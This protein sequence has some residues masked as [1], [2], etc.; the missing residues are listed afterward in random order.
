MT[1]VL[2]PRRVSKVKVGLAIMLVLGMMAGMWYVYQLW[3]DGQTTT[4]ANQNSAS[5]TSKPTQV[6]GLST[7]KI[8]HQPPK[9]ASRLPSGVESN[10]KPSEDPGLI[11]S[12]MGRLSGLETS[13]AEMGEK[14][15]HTYKP[16]GPGAK[17]S[18]AAKPAHAAKTPDPH[19]ALRQKALAES[20]KAPLVV[21]ST[22]AK[23]TDA[24]EELRTLQPGWKIPFFVE[25]AVHSDIASEF[26]GRVSETVYASS[27]HRVPL[28]PLGATVLGTARAGQLIPGNERLPMASVSVSIP[29][30]KP[31]EIHSMPIIDE[32][33]K[34]GMVDDIDHHYVRQ[35][36]GVLVGGFLRGAT[37]E[38]QSQSNKLGPVGSVTEGVASGAQ[39]AAG[40]QL[41]QLYSV[42][43]TIQ[44]YRGSRGYILITK[45]LKI[46]GATEGVK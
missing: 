36:F 15:S 44:V 38:I 7:E 23:A 8:R 6:N 29:G 26:T 31:V 20:R 10:G 35:A 14:L 17:P 4:H 21:V 11:D 12:V 45:P 22:G 25:T 9:D 5:T 30:M 19:I 27:A 3:I 39:Q 33:G 16:P 37:R 46:P 43:P 34:A 42:K 18:N 24:Q 41:Q 28:I 13:I 32:E 2:M 1:D 40:P